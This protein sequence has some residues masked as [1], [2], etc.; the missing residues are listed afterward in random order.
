MFNKRRRRKPRLIQ[1]ALRGA[2]AGVVGGL[3]VTLAERELINRV[4]GGTPHRAGWDDS[5]QHQLKRAGIHVGGRGA[6]AAGV[7]S[8]LAYSGALGAAYAVL[9][10]R[11]TESRAGR[12]LLDGA[13]IYAASFV[14]PDQP[15]PRRRGRR[16]PLRRTLVERV[17][18]AAAF[19]RA[20]TMALGVMSR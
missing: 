18:T 3:A 17:N 5:L 12:A 19:S 15:K 16:L 14:F 20:T 8:Q 1:T 11:A 10:E 6:I 13:L 4:D 2:A 9:S 7:I